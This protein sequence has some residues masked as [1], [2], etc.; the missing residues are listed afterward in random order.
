MAVKLFKALGCGRLEVCDKVVAFRLFLKSSE[1]HLGA[2]DILLGI[3][4]VLKQSSLVPFNA[5]A[6]V[7]LGV[8][9]SGSLTRVP[10]KKAVKVG[11]LLVSS[12]GLDSVALCAL[13]LE[14]LGPLSNVSHFRV[15]W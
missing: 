11:T 8:R 13:G 15:L 10:P 9:V 4:Q 14:N 7:G 3:F 6:H 5:L 1:N 12:A 2:W